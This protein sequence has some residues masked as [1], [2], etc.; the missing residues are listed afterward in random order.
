MSEKG[1]FFTRTMNMNKTAKF[2]KTNKNSKLLLKTHSHFLRIDQNYRT[3]F[4]VIVEGLQ[5]ARKEE[6]NLIKMAHMKK[7]PVYL[8]KRTKDKALK[9]EYKAEVEAYRKIELF[10]L[11]QQKY[12]KNILKLQHSFK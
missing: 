5:S 10:P 11:K 2:D 7:S 4:Y 3:D 1:D 12:P 9:A 8:L 6:I